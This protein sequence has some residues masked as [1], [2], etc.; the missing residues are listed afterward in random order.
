MSNEYIRD[1]QGISINLNH[2]QESSSSFDLKDIVD[3][4]GAGDE[5]E[6]VARSPEHVRVRVC[7]LIYPLVIWHS[8]GKSPFIV[9]FPMKNSDFPQ[10]C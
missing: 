7:K 9:D 3:V 2:W 10:L 5:A 8:Y 6:A 4:E 1:I